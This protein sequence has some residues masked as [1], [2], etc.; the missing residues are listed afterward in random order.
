MQQGI[1]GPDAAYVIRRFP[2]IF[3]RL[4]HIEPLSF[5]TQEKSCATQRQCRPRL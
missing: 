3:L 5:F 4:I 1:D 2:A